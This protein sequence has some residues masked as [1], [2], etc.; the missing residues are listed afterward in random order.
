[1]AIGFDKGFQLHTQGMLIRSQRSEVI[2][3]NIA[4][5]DTPGYKA[6]GLDLASKNKILVPKSY[7][8]PQEFWEDFENKIE[9][10][11]SIKSHI[12]DGVALTKFIFWLK[13]N[14]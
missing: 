10:K 5:A 7:L 6:K 8:I 11:N 2:A 4:N 3:S 12:Y 13:N 1:M 9:I 14:F